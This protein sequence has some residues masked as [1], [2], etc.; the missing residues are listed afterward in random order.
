MTHTTQQVDT[1]TDTTE[2]KTRSIASTDSTNDDDVHV[3]QFNRKLDI[4]SE[5]ICGNIILAFSQIYDK[6]IDDDGAVYM[7]NISSRNRNRLKYLFDVYY[8]KTQTGKKNIENINNRHVKTS[9]KFSFKLTFGMTRSVAIDKKNAMCFVKEM[10]KNYF[11]NS[12]NPEND[13]T[14]FELLEW[15][16]KTIINPMDAALLEIVFLMND[17]FSRFK[18]QNRE[19]FHQLCEQVAE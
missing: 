5:N 9:T 17:S 6:Y 10:V 18:T 14:E 3:L 13:K 15:L 1:D 4:I 8:Y 7:I 16:F 12:S 11:K 19:L 2:H